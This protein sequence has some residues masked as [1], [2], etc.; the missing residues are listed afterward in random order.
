M[1][2]ADTVMVMKSRFKFHDAFAVILAAIDSVDDG[3]SFPF[4]T[5]IDIDNFRAVARMPRPPDV[6]RLVGSVSA[7]PRCHQLSCGHRLPLTAVQR[8]TALPVES[9]TTRAQI[10]ISN[11]G[12]SE[13]C[14]PASCSSTVSCYQS[15]LRYSTIFSYLPTHNRQ[16]LPNLARG[17]KHVLTTSLHTYQ[18]ARST[19][20]RLSP[21]RLDD[22]YR[23]ALGIPSAKPAAD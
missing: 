13:K 2:R 3:E 15:R 23:V 16:P 4:H 21:E 12:A 11:A 1:H 22:G 7:V 17:T 5:V 6:I 14:V 9:P 20:S 19:A 8:A 18:L 10:G